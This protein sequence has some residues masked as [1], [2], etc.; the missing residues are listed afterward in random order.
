MCIRDSDISPGVYV[1]PNIYLIHH[2]P[3]IYPEPFRFRPERFL[4][5]E[6]SPYEYMPFGGG[7]RRC[8][9]MALSLFEMRIVLGT[10]LRHL[11]FAALSPGAV[12]YTHLAVGALLGF[13]LLGGAEAVAY[14]HGDRRRPGRSLRNA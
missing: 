6:Y 10:L 14:P 5:K 13:C 4:E 9:G 12:S 7:A 8:I 2:D 11:R 1:S 3:S